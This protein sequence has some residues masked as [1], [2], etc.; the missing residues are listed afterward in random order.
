MRGHANRSNKEPLPAVVQALNDLTKDERNTVF[1]ISSEMKQLMHKWYAQS[2][3]QLGLAAE[4][5]FF[6]RLDSVNKDE[7][8]WIKLMPRVVDL[9]YS[10]SP[11]LMWVQLLDRVSEG[12]PA[13]LHRE[14]RQRIH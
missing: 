7:H 10:L 8:K 14:D 1:V 6:W 9:Y 5:G 12:H 2:A 13:E 3:P 11:L 4:N